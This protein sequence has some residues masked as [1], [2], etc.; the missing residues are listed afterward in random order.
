MKRGNMDN[1]GIVKV[2]GRG[3]PLPGDDID[4]DRIVPARFLKA[5]TFDGF[6]NHLFYDERERQP[7][8]PLDEPGYKGGKIL[9]V[10]RNFGSGSSREHAP[11]AILRFGVKSIVGVS[12]AE[13]FTGNCLAIGLPA[14]T[15]SPEVLDLLM[16]QTQEHPDT[17]YTVD[18]KNLKLSS[19][20]VAYD[21]QISEERKNAFMNGT[22]NSLA[23]LRANKDKVRRTADALPYI[24][25]FR[26]A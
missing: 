25:G 7:N 19:K 17:V 20:E 6:E 22:W 23:I 8:H 15:A 10:G 12:F 2:E 26:K 16:R 21:I 11:Q 4:T 24:S 1:P 18:L 9:F 3:I 14:V 5:I 13:I